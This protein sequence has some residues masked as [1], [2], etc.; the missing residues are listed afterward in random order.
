MRSRLCVRRVAGTLAILLW[1]AAAQTIFAGKTQIAARPNL[2]HAETEADVIL[3]VSGQDGHPEIYVVNADGSNLKRLTYSEHGSIL[4]RWSPDGNHIAYLSGGDG[5]T[6]LYVMD[7][8]GAHQMRLTFSGEYRS[9]PQWWPDN[10]HISL[11]SGHT[12]QKLNIDGSTPQSLFDINGNA[13]NDLP[14]PVILSPDG[15]AIAVRGITFLQSEWIQAQ[16]FV[17]YNLNAP[18]GLWSPDSAHILYTDVQGKAVL[19]YMRNLDGS[20]PTFNNNG[21]YFQNLPLGNEHMVWSPNGNYI[22][23][24]CCAVLAPH[25]PEREI[26]IVVVSDLESATQSRVERLTTVEILPD[27]PGKRGMFDPPVFLSG[28]SW[29]PDS[30]QLVFTFNAGRYEL[31]VMNVDGSGRESILVRDTPLYDPHWSPIR[32]P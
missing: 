6:D 11:F 32:R 14:P 10:Q 28:F 18:E 12:F 16:P 1:L 13:Y 27:D 20:R 15:N 24:E 9:A 31:A 7:A 4:P 23:A 17:V 25:G 29:A 26:T 3:F 8:D 22:V 2:V 5:H 30:Q 19:V 21:P